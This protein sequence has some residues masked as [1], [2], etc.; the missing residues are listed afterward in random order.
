MTNTEDQ[1]SWKYLPTRAHLFEKSLSKHS[2]GAYI[3]LCRE[4]GASFEAVAGKVYIPIHYL[5]RFQLIPGLAYIVHKSQ[6]KFHGE[7]LGIRDR[8][9]NLED[10][11][12]QVERC[13]YSRGAAEERS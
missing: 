9:F 8:K 6:R 5:R 11:G 4:V 1:Y 10:G 7:N 3:E 12:E 2:I 13:R